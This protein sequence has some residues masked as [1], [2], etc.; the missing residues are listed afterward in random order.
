MHAEHANASARY[1]GLGS[2][3]WCVY[4]ACFYPRVLR[5][6]P[7]YICAKILAFL[8]LHTNSYDITPSPSGQSLCATWLISVSRS[9]CHHHFAD[10][11]TQQVGGM[12]SQ[13]TGLAVPERKFLAGRED[14]AG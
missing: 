10:R 11:C 5:A 3:D 9:G 8:M 12:F 1:T 4:K 7:S 6:S 2:D 14:F 13:M